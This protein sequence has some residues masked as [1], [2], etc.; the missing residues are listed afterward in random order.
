MMN[1]IIMLSL[2]YYRKI[3]VLMNA[4]S[5]LY[6]IQQFPSKRNTTKFKGFRN[7]M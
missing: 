3:Y 4:K 5:R 1:M 2:Y 6:S 7:F